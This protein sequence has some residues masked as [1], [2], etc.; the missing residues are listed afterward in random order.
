MEVGHGPTTGVCADKAIAISE[1]AG[2]GVYHQARMLY[3]L[4]T[5]HEHVPTIAFD[6]LSWM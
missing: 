6:V 4:G 5:T 3:G 1:H 2:L